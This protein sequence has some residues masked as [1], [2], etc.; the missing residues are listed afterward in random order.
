MPVIALSD[1]DFTNLKAISEPFVD[2]SPEARISR[3]I[4]DEMTRMGVTSSVNGAAHV[5]G[6]GRSTPEPL[7]R[8]SVDAHGSLSFTKLVSASVDG[9]EMHRPKWNS[10]MNHVHILGLKR[11]GNLDALK[12][13]TGARLRPGRYEEEGFK[14]L[15]EGDF[16]IQGVDSNAAWDHSLAVARALRMPIKATFQWR[17]DGA[18][19]GQTGV[20]EWNPSKS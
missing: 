1:A 15:P 11:L 4:R 19:P 13:A 5:D 10:L 3:L 8:L 2:P 16:S 6:R 18:Y 14:Y 9:R 17:E 20:L 7:R 12:R